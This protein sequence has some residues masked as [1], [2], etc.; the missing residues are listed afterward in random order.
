[1]KAMWLAFAG[2]IAISLVAWLALDR[3]DTSSAGRYSTENVR[4]D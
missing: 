2:I 3:F 4:I 1:M